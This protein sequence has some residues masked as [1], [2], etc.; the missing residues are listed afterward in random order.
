MKSRAS[1]AFAMEKGDAV[2]CTVSE[3]RAAGVVRLKKRI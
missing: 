1:L 3:F 2:C